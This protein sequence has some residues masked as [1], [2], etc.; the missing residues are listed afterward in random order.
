MGDN[1]ILETPPVEDT[2]ACGQ[3]NLKTIVDYFNNKDGIKL[4]EFQ[5]HTSNTTSEMV[6]F[7]TDRKTLE[8]PYYEYEKL[9][10]NKNLDV[11]AL[12][13]RAVGGAKTI[14]DSDFDKKKILNPRKEDILDW[15]PGIN[16]KTFIELNGIYPDTFDLI[17]KLKNRDIQTDYKWDDSNKDLMTHN[18]ILNGTK[19]YL[20]DFD[21][22][23]IERDI[24]DDKLQIET[25]IDEI[26]RFLNVDDIYVSKNTKSKTN[27]C[28]Y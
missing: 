22:K 5:R 16:L 2:G 8:W 18:L 19:L 14:L 23:L 4:G 7:K 17:E 24:F 3:N 12:K 13:A 6:W 10:N 20:I 28:H 25:I 15:I 9:F 26:G 27:N 21:D 11:E 1:L